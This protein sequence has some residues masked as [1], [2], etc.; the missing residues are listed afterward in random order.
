MRLHFPD[1]HEAKLWKLW[2]FFCSMLTMHITIIP[3]VHYGAS[4]WEGLIKNV[5]FSKFHSPS[6]P[7]SAIALKRTDSAFWPFP[8]ILISSHPEVN[9][10][11][12]MYLCS[13]IGFW[14][15]VNSLPVTHGAAHRFV[16]NLARKVGNIIIRLFFGRFMK[17][18]INSTP[19][20]GQSSGRSAL[21]DLWD[22][23]CGSA[24]NASQK[25]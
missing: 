5:C 11:G 21:S 14:A 13:A 10:Y 18:E 8:R 25:L 17:T 12:C 3:L 4:Y 2:F 15:R 19:R 24:D 23:R 1:Y 6:G 7:I 20:A 16:C 9:V 22:L